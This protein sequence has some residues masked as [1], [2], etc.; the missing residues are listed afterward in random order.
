[1][2][3]ESTKKYLHALSCVRDGMVGIIEASPTEIQEFISYLQTKKR[4]LVQDIR[5][6]HVLDRHT[7]SSVP[8]IHTLRLELEAY[9]FP[10]GYPDPD[11]STSIEK[12]LSK[13]TTDGGEVSSLENLF[14]YLECIVD[15]TGESLKESSHTALKQLAPHV[16]VIVPILRLS[17]M[18][19]AFAKCIST[20]RQEFI[21]DPL[22]LDKLRFDGR[23]VS[24]TNLVFG[25][26]YAL[27]HEDIPEH[28][29]KIQ[30]SSFHGDNVPVVIVVE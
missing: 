26:T 12:A 29:V 2:K 7:Q 3:D 15:N 20:G 23:S 9:L 6:G 25:Q 14:Q 10:R 22:V 30:V 16:P 1:V 24:E 27:S 11:R 17:G 13:K 18:P 5:K 21:L 4:D 8:V 19:I 28:S